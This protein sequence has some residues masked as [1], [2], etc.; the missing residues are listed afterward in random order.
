MP[1]DPEISV[2]R[3]QTRRPKSR[4][5]LSL[6]CLI[7]LFGWMAIWGYFHR[8]EFRQLLSF[9]PWLIIEQLPLA[10]VSIVLI[11]ILNQ[12]AGQGLQ[13][14]IGLSEW[15]RISLAANLANYI[16]PFRAGMFLRAAYLKNI[17]GLPVALFGSITGA[18]SILMLLIAAVV[19][20]IVMMSRQAESTQ[21]GLV[22]N[23]VFSLTAV[24]CL[25]FW[26]LSL[27]SK[28]LSGSQWIPERVRAFGIGMV[29]L[30]Q[31]TSVL[32][33][34]IAVGSGLLAVSSARLFLSY[35][36]V[37]WDVEPLDCTLVAC[38]LSMSIVVAITPAGLGVQEAIGV[39]GS[40]LVGVPPEVGLA[41]L[42]VNRGV[43]MVVAFTL[44]P[45]ALS[46]ISRRLKMK[47]D[48]T[49]QDFSG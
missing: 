18:I 36:A 39:A 35:S 26:G 23:I 32:A 27:F 21:P 17:H 3:P 29:R 41:A 47:T 43:S 14:R 42:L 37:G 22:L 1:N 16:F 48:L 11:G 38:V 19:G 9:Q 24:G 33:Q 45:F 28:R 10:V 13:I 12:I 46:G 49:S 31:S 25:V 40:T 6:S 4:Q 7:G 30:C 2:S 5:I 44:G 8:D 15:V 20:C 34:L